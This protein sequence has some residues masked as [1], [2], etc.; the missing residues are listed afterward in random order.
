MKYFQY[1]NKVFYLFTYILCARIPF[2]VPKNAV[3]MLCINIICGILDG[4]RFWL[5]P[6]VMPGVSNVKFKKES[7]RHPVVVGHISVYAQPLCW[8]TSCLD[9]TGAFYQCLMAAFV[10]PSLT[11]WLICQ[12]PG[13]IE[14]FGVFNENWYNLCLNHI[15]WM[16][17]S[18]PCATDFGRST[19]RTT[20]WNSYFWVAHSK[21][22][23]LK[24]FSPLKLNRYAC[25]VYTTGWVDCLPTTFPRELHIFILP[26]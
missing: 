14:D 15:I 21:I 24:P 7:D 22:H 26:V 6:R 1:F 2:C 8:V 11:F 16:E 4:N 18:P 20:D 25:W 10:W 9:S 3:G 19:F 12:F 23:H 5:F 13:V 17:Y